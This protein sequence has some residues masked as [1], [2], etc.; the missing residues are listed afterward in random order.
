MHDRPYVPAALHM[1][2]GIL[3]RMQRYRLK[4]TPK[5]RKLPISEL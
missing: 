5:L 4:K 1:L 3:R 2:D